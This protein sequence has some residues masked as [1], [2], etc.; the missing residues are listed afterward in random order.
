MQTDF[1][2]IRFEEETPRANIRTRRFVCRNQR[3]GDELG[4]VLYFAGWRQYVFEPVCDLVVFNAGC[5][6]DIAQFLE[7]LRNGRSR[8]KGG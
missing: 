8:A 2:W 6:R 1:K 4:R 5:L 7:G 3:S